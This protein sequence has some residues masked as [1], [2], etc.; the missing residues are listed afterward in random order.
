M[1]CRLTRR[2]AAIDLQ[3]PQPTRARAREFHPPRFP[4][5]MPAPMPGSILEASKCFLAGAV[6]S[7]WLQ[8][9]GG[10]RGWQE[11]AVGAARPLGNQR[12]R[13]PPPSSSRSISRAGGARPV[14]DAAAGEEPAGAA[15]RRRSRSRG[16]GVGLQAWQRQGTQQAPCAPRPGG[17]RAWQHRSQQRGG[18]SNTLR[19]LSLFSGPPTTMCLLECNMVA[20]VRPKTANEDK[21]AR[22]QSV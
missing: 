6:E 1:R 17:G 12:W 20:K 10:G 15:G 3:H 11:Q 18:K 4:P 5:P 7:G 14:P 16:S 2:A 19:L 21:L 9:A 22:K 8:P 13:P